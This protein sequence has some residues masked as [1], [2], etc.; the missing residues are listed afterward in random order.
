MISHGE[1][2]EKITNPRIKTPSQGVG[3][4]EEAETEAEGE[5]EGEENEGE[6]WIPM[7]KRIKG[8]SSKRKFQRG[9]AA[10]I[11][12]TRAETRR[13]LIK[14]CAEELGA[15]KDLLGEMDKEFVTAAMKTIVEKA[16]AA[17]PDIEE[18]DKMKID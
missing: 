16:V 9:R 1:D 5:G 6:G 15:L 3:E 12:E 18:D 8:S 17:Y 13:E 10:G 14:I 11:A 7:R 2:K 4:G